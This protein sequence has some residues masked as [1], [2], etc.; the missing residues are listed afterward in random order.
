MPD[1]VKDAIISIASA[2]KAQLESWLL[3]HGF[4]ADHR[5]TSDDGAITFY[6]VKEITLQQRDDLAKIGAEV[7]SEW[8]AGEMQSAVE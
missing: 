3:G 1:Q 5:Q 4:L 6:A 8:K 2:H 7:I